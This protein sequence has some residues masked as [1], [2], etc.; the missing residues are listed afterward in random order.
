MKT[1]ILADPLVVEYKLNSAL[2][3]VSLV[4]ETWIISSLGYRQIE[5]RN[6]T[7]FLCFFVEKTSVS[8]LNLTEPV[9]VT[10]RIGSEATHEAF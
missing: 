2:F 9:S 6:L 3:C 10:E 5:M 8:E 7:S 1:N 4:V